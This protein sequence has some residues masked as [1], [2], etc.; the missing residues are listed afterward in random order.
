M[1]FVYLLNIN[2]IIVEKEEENVKVNDCV[3]REEE[4]N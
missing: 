2:K 1:I 4:G 3:S